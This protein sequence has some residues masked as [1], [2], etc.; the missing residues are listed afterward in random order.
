MV[1]VI[2][3]TFSYLYH[4]LFSLLV[5]GLGAIAWLSPS[6]RLEL[7]MLPWWEDPAL[8]TWLFFGGLAGL[9]SLALAYSGRLQILFRLWTV[10]ALAIL[11]YGFFLTPYGFRSPGQFYNTV[12]AALGGLVAAVG[13]WLRVPKPE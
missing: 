12:L 5:F 11:V 8:S 4:F 3:R 6:T 10:A 9:L 2:L 1:R 13:A 7:P